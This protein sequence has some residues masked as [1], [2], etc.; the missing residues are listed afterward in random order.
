MRQWRRAEE[1]KPTLDSGQRM[2]GKQ[3]GPYPAASRPAKAC[4]CMAITKSPYYCN[5]HCLF[6]T[7]RAPCSP[8][9]KVHASLLLILYKSCCRVWSAYVLRELAT[10]DQAHGSGRPCRQPLATTTAV[11]RFDFSH[12]PQRT[13]D[14]R[15]RKERLNRGGERQDKSTLL[16][17]GRPPFHLH[18]SAS[19]QSHKGKHHLHHPAGSSPRTALANQPGSHLFK[20]GTVPVPAHAKDEKSDWVRAVVP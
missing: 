3:D 6:G 13:A 2:N 14:V 15:A 17:A 10:N 7:F 20:I 16:S 8:S 19:V 12:V 4:F 1:H 11:F 5:R 9:A 18:G